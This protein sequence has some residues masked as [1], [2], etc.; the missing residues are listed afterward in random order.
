MMRFYRGG[1]W[2]SL[3][4]ASQKT[5]KQTKTFDPELGANQGGKDPTN[6]VQRIRR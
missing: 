5:N 6:A 1:N 3:E 4:R 2:I